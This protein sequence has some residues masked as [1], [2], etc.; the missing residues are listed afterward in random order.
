M[1]VWEKVLLVD[2][3]WV[4]LLEVVVLVVPVEVEE[5]ETDVVDVTSKKSHHD[6]LDGARQP[7]GL[8][9]ANPLNA[10]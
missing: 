3:V 5:V 2:V 8:L 7:R 9:Q 1:L 4:A 6:R 10:F